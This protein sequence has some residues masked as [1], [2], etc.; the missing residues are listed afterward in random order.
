MQVL[1][2]ISSKSE[3]FQSS[4]YYFPKPLI[5]VCGKPMIESVIESIKTYI[6]DP[7]FI[8]V[9]DSEDCTKYSLDKMLIILGGPN[10]KIIEKS[11][12]TAGALCSA[13]LAYDHLKP[14]EPLLISNCDT[15]LNGN[16][17]GKMHELTEGE[18]AA[19][20]FTFSSI[21]PRWSYVRSKNTPVVDQV[22]E[23][24]V[25]SKKAIAGIY[26]FKRAQ[27]FVS[28]AEEVILND[29]SIDNNFYISSTLNQII[30]KNETVI[31]VELNLDQV[32]TLYSPEAIKQY[33]NTLN[34]PMSAVGDSL[35]NIIIPAAGLG[36]RFHDQGW[37]KPKPFIDVCGKTMLENVITNLNT[38]NSNFTVLARSE[39]IQEY[40]QVIDR[41][42]K[43]GITIAAVP[44]LTEGT[45]C[46]VLSVEEKINND[47]YLLIA[48]SDQIV[49]FDVQDYI[50][51]CS[52]RNLDGS[53]L[54]FKDEKRDPKWSFAKVS[55]DGFVV[56]VAEKKPISEFAT[57]GIYLF[58]SGSSFVR[59]AIEM[60]VANERINNEFYTCPVYN[61]LIKKGL[62]IGIYEISENDMNGIGTPSDLK[63]YLKLNNFEASKDE[64]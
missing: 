7:T 19:S 32:H 21:H 17:A 24:D 31:S 57:V 38:K 33:E 63:S 52:E 46:T 1:I 59:A 37:K 22:Y 61:Y 49:D 56:E 44:K 55:P 9:V 40:P 26:Y 58:K 50:K 2:P 4:D 16:I 47:N 34:N 8:F 45:A 36:S 60:I 53:I 12:E 35:I 39:H 5:Q 30:L 15:L 6:G 54:V 25:V 20:V 23:K 62:K 41:L 29:V 43:S 10:T 64:P 18:I 48:N 51:D 14:N 3:F 11:S 13:L 27:Y 28:A 42:Q